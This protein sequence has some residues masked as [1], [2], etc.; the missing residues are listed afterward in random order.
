MTEERPILCGSRPETHDRATG[1]AGSFERTVEAIR[2][3]PGSKPVI[4]LSRYSFFELPEIVRLWSELTQNSIPEGIDFELE[5]L[6]SVAKRFAELTATLE[7]AGIPLSAVDAELPDLLETVERAANAGTVSETTLLRLLGI[8]CD[9]AFVGP[10]RLLFDPLYACNLD[11]IYCNNFSVARTN[12][13]EELVR[14]HPLYRFRGRRLEPERFKELLREAKKLRVSAISIVGS[15]EP[16]L[17][18]HLIEILEYAHALGFDAIDISTNG[19]K[20][21]KELAEAVIDCKLTSVTFSITGASKESFARFH[22]R[23]AKHYETIMK[24]IKHLA[25]LKKRR[26][27]EHPGL[28]ALSVITKDNIDEMTEFVEHAYALGCDK[29]WFQLIHPREFSKELE[30]DADDIEK[31]RAEYARAKKRAD[32]LPIAMSWEFEY[33]LERIRPGGSWTGPQL[34]SCPVGWWF[35]IITCAERVN[36]CCGWKQVGNIEGESFKA[37]W[38]SERYRAYRHFGKHIYRFGSVVKFENGKRLLDDF[39]FWC[40]NFNFVAEIFGLLERTGLLKFYSHD[41]P[42]DGFLESV[43]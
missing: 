12:V 21:P 29:V 30:L 11:C 34:K 40:D 25:E 38:N 24:N 9:K 14:S 5:P 36:F 18:P 35:S 39:C 4:G 13:P 10:H 31:L 19:I 32:E 15:G 17:Y 16:T 20:F 8:L 23:G 6:N 28:I 2:S 22:P 42:F 33:Q 1:E 41:K 37:L 27:S 7:R 26:K 43:P 3:N